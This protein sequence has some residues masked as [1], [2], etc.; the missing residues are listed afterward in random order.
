MF[1]SGPTFWPPARKNRKVGN[2]KVSRLPPPLPK[3]KP[4]LQP[5][6]V[7]YHLLYTEGKLLIP[8]SQ[9]AMN[10]TE[11]P[12]KNNQGYVG[13]SWSSHPLPTLIPLFM[14]LWW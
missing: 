10:R 13:G 14:E 2:V 6:S 5:A 4:H 1:L 12:A 3:E 11:P 7:C 8:L 9:L